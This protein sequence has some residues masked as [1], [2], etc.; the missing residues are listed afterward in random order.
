MLFGIPFLTIPLLYWRP[1]MWYPHSYK[2]PWLFRGQPTGYLSSLPPVLSA[3]G[4]QM[5]IHMAFL[6]RGAYIII[7]R[8]QHICFGYMKQKVIRFRREG[9]K[10][11]YMLSFSILDLPLSPAVSLTSPPSVLPPMENSSHTGEVTDESHLKHDIPAYQNSSSP[12]NK[13]RRI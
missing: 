1:R 9:T 8:Q 3:A 2:P 7:W 4:R 5:D 6:D 11:R 13:R 12:N 10:L